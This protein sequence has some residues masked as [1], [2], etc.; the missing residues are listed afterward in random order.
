[1]NNSIFN[2]EWCTLKENQQHAFR[3]GLNHGKRGTANNNAKLP[4]QMAK[5]IINDYQ[6]GTYTYR[7]LAKK[8]HVGHSTI[9][10]VITKSITY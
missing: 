1:M 7:E 3:I 10:N 6:S 8:Y 2:I 4:S 5:D 9:G